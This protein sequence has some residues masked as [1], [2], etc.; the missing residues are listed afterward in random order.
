MV[1]ETEIKIASILSLTGAH[2]MR[3]DAEQALR[4]QIL[5]EIES[6]RAMLESLRTRLKAGQLDTEAS[7]AVDLLDSR[8]SSLDALEQTAH[9]SHSLSALMNMTYAL[10]AQNA[11]TLS[12]I[13][14]A[15]TDALNQSGHALGELTTE[16][17]A[18][19]SRAI[20]S[21]VRGTDAANARHFGTAMS[22]LDAR[23]LGRH[24]RGVQS[25]LEKERDEAAKRG[26]H[27]TARV[28][29]AL[30]GHNTL[31]A[32]DKALEVEADPKKREHLE[33]ERQ[34]QI[35]VIAEREA[36]MRKQLELDGR[37]AAQQDGL[38]GKQAED[39]ARGHADRQMDA[40]RERAKR[41]HE[42]AGSPSAGRRQETL[43]EIER[44]R[45]VRQGQVDEDLHKARLERVETDA[46]RI[47]SGRMPLA[48]KTAPEAVV[49]EATAH[50]AQR[51]LRRAQA[52]AIDDTIVGGESFSGDKTSKFAAAADQFRIEQLE[53]PNIRAERTQPDGAEP[54]PPGPTPSGVS[55][56]V[57]STHRG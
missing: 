55:K 10:P 56:P 15:R 4:E 28:A 35:D 39:Y 52:A 13:S 45:L 18:H 53:K 38:T 22:V 44:S 43:D 32:L 6:Q 21:R 37:R 49:N 29:D 27:G 36:A 2:T 47:A 40:Y 41:M 7:D 25:E 3:K 1:A 31:N 5:R 54:E 8:L 34:R 33:A 50:A 26:E 48:A 9:Q 46:Q 20:E 42:D 16:Y 17:Y 30:L 14:S 12:A 57:A 51:A 23:G 11:L 24:F 19:Y